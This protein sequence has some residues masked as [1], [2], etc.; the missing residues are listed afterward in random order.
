M[1]LDGANGR[2]QFARVCLDRRVLTVVTR[3]ALVQHLRHPARRS[4]QVPNQRGRVAAAHAARHDAAAARVPLGRDLAVRDALGG[5]RTKG[6]VLVGVIK[7]AARFQH[8]LAKAH[9]STR[10]KSE[11]LIQASTSMN[12]DSC[13]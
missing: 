3:A 2:A 1:G 13:T 9:K 7:A 10:Q 8:A 4:D 6:E 12:E 5:A 11:D